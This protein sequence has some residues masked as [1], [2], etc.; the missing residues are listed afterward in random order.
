MRRLRLPAAGV[1]LGVLAVGIAA[2]VRT[3]AAL[4]AAGLILFFVAGPCLGWTAY[5]VVH[6]RVG[7][8]GNVRSARREPR[9]E[10][11]A[12]GD[13]ALLEAHDFLEK[14]FENSADAV[15]LV[16][17]RG[18]ITRFNKATT[19]LFG[20][21]LEEIAGQSGFSVYPDQKALEEMLD[22]LRRDGQVRRYEIEMRH[23]E[24]RVFP[25]EIS[26]GMLR[27]DEGRT[28]GSVA[29]IRDLSE[30]KKA[31][32][33]AQ[34]SERM[35]TQFLTTVSHELRT[36]LASV[37]GYARLVRKSLD[38]AV[39]PALPGGDPQTERA[40][41]RLSDNV[42][43]ILAQAKRLTAVINDVLDIANM[44]AG[45]VSWDMRPLSVEAII[46]RAVERVG[47]LFAGKSLHLSTDVEEDLPEVLGDR[48]RLI[49]VLTQLISNAVKFTDSGSVTCAARREASTVV[50]SVSDTGMGIDPSDQER[51]FDKFQQGGEDP[52][53]KPSGTG[54]G[55]TICREI[56]ARHG[57]RFRVESRQGEGSTFSFTLP[58]RE[59]DRKVVRIDLS[60]V[61]A[62]LLRRSD[63]GGVRLTLGRSVFVVDDEATIRRL[64]QG[65]LSS[66]GYRVSTAGHGMSAIA[67]IKS[68][69]PDLVILD[70]KM[71]DIGGLDVAAILK[72]ETATQEIPIIMFSVAD[73]Q[74]RARRLGVEGYLRKPLDPPALFA[75]MDRVWTGRRRGWD[76]LVGDTRIGE[77]RL[78]A[79]RLRSH[80]FQV[81]LADMDADS[82]AGAAAKGPDMILMSGDPQ[83]VGSLLRTLR[84][85]GGTDDIR[86]ILLTETGEEG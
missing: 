25:A 21:R 79:D 76:V 42:E 34:E 47:P 78:L 82:L 33:A 27:D 86:F 57:G 49:Q 75:E 84:G 74:E 62:R 64:L 40:A 32:K 3:P 66:A 18:R 63:N 31:M 11:C 24:G 17:H 55:L 48:N 53:D 56:V 65:V 22:R 28:L 30:I 19:E 15:V 41:R 26:I 4:W 59:P 2:G 23:A 35:K 14:V 67:R 13:G 58:V 12:A 6:K 38:E 43:V 44:E 7:P 71:P 36:P 9:I 45:R 8:R 60:A 70:V 29:V 52:A 54:V 85:P 50:V 68:E 51:I 77:V 83:A 69:R 72:S 16:D 46:H 10:P 73:E 81:V 20:Y 80:G 1:G 39:L 37:L 5:L 61:N